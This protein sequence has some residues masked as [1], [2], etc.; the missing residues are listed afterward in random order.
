MREPPRPAVW[1]LAHRLSDEWRDFIVG[2]LIEEFAERSVSS[3]AR[4]R[5]W[6]WRQTVRCLIAP[7]P[8]PQQARVVAPIA[9]PGDS[10]LRTV[11]ADVRYGLRVLTRAP[12]F[13]LAVVIVLALGIGANTRDLQHRQHRVVA[14][15]AVRSARSARAYL[16]CA[17]AGGVPGHA[18]ASPSRRQISTTGSS[19]RS[20]STR[21][22]C[23]G[24]VSSR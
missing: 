11:V 14:S 23:T 24:S 15:A 22:L 8:A 2:D 7:P 4:A 16:S 9:P 17:A 6:F 3:P 10:M 13:S 19:A 5:A 21:W 12:S 20:C 18:A 1:L